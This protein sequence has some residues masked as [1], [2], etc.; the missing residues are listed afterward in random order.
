MEL[1]KSKYYRPVKIFE[2][3]NIAGS[4]TF[5]VKNLKDEVSNA[6]S[7]FSTILD[8]LFPYVNLNS[9]EMVI[10]TDKL[11][12]FD[13]CTDFHT[14]S[15]NNKKR[16]LYVSEAC[17]FHPEFEFFILTDEDLS[18]DYNES[19]FESSLSRVTYIYYNSRNKDSFK[20]LEMF[21]D[22]YLQ[23]YV[24]KEAKISLLI[25]QG[26]DLLFKNH[27]IKP[28]NINLSTMYNDDFMSVHKKIKNDLINTN[29]GVVLLHGIAGSGKTNYIKWLTSQIPDKD[30]IFVPN[31]MIQVLTDPDFINLLMDKKSSVIVLED[32]ENYI[33]ERSLSNTQGDG[34]ASILNITDGLLSDVLEC[35]FICTFNA[36]ITE[37]DHALLRKGRLIAEY[38]FDKLSVEK[39][40][41]YLKSIEK[42]F[43]VDKPYSLAE[44]VHID[45]EEFISQKKKHIGF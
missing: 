25:K 26:Q 33:A 27:K 15:Y 35:Q 1:L 22:K 12:E 18:N 42:D 43:E 36:K 3:E 24:S 4:Q 28:Y 7:P 23:K 31:N 10:H 14:V 9:A 39:C 40:N 41:T 34:V 16:K 29:K 20:Y 19:I 13:K 45:E 6:T 11:K 32:C 38:Y 44:I 30:F 17:Y 2:E 21:I 37:I 8:R 5:T